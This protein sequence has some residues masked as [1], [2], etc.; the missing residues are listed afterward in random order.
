MR[1]LA[2]SLDGKEVRVREKL[3]D[4]WCS[5]LVA[6]K[7]VGKGDEE[8]MEYFGGMVPRLLGQVK[9]QAREGIKEACAKRREALEAEFHSGSKKKWLNRVLGRWSRNMDVRHCWVRE[10]GGVVLSGDMK[11]VRKSGL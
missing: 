2:R 6:V 11:E 4:R 3:G 7:V 8:V 10:G 9:W 1:R 5:D